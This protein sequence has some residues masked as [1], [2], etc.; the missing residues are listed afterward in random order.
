[1]PGMPSLTEPVGGGVMGQIVVD[2]SCSAPLME[3]LSTHTR[4]SH[5]ALSLFVLPGIA[6]RQW[7]RHA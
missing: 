6:L 7:P 4:P 1:M 2:M 5:Q 3:Q